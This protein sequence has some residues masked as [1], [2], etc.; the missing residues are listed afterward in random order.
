MER[1]YDTWTEERMTIDTA[2]KDIKE[3]IE[4]L[5]NKI[6]NNKRTGHTAHNRS[7]YASPPFGRLGLRFC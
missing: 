2:N 7:V 1:E 6:E 3:C 5:I 4:E